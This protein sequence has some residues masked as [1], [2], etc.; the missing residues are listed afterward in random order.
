MLIE[1]TKERLGYHL[2]KGFRVKVVLDFN[3]EIDKDIVLVVGLR[4][5]RAIGAASWCGDCCSI[6]LGAG[7]AD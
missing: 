7:F 2:C 4:P 3:G 1:T 5:L 6:R